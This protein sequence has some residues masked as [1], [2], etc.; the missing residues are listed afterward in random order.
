MQAKILSILAF[1]AVSS[2]AQTTSID[3]PLLDAAD[4]EDVVPT[5]ILSPAEATSIAAVADSFIASVTAAPQFSS[6]VS[7]LATGIPI[8]AQAEIENDPTDFLLDLVRGS[9]LPAWATALPPSVGEYI[10]SVAEAA[11]A[12]ATSDFAA[13]YTS[14]SAEVAA[15]ETGAPS[16]G[17]YIFPSGGYVQSNSTTFNSTAGPQPTGSAVVPGT[18]PQPFPGAATSL[19]SGNTAVALVI[20]SIGALMLL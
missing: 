19:K 5:Q 6:V 4:I 11:A 9:P 14:V 15:L 2:I 20:A 17:G 3:Q 16:S 12:V 13:L 8:T 10:E 7:V 18:T 1:C